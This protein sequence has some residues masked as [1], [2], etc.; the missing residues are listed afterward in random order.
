MGLPSDLSTMKSNYE[1]IPDFAHLAADLGV[2]GVKFTNVLLYSRSDIDETEIFDPLDP[3]WKEAE[4]MILE[5]QG[6]LSHHGI[7]LYYTSPGDNRDDR[8]SG[9]FD[10]NYD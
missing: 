3:E 9:D 4:Q 8:L 1:Q 2:D 5:A 7:H 10:S 6:F